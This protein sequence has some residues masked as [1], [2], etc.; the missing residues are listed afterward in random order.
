MN[1]NVLLDTDSYKITHWRQYPP[2]TTRVSSFL[3]SR[4]GVYPSTVFFGLQYILQ[5]HLV[6]PVVTE[7]AIAEA[8]DLCAA[9]FGDPSLFHEAGW[10]HVLEAH[11]GRLPVEIRA[12]PEG[13]EVPVSNVLMTIEN[14]DPRVPWLTNYLESLLLQVWYPC[15][16]ATQ[17]RHM[18][19]TIE[20]YLERTGDPSLASFKLHDFGLRG[21]TSIESSGIGGAAHLVSFQGTDTLPAL[22]L[23]RRHYGAEM[24]GFSIPA[25]EH[26]T[27][28]SWGRDREA[29]AYRNMLESYP[30]GLVAVVSDSYDVFRACAELWGGQLRDAVLARDG[31][32][33][34]R[35][36]SGEPP[37]VVCRV[38]EILG[39]AF[40]TR[41]NDKGYRV[42]DPHV[43]VIQGDGIDH[44]MIVD[45][46]EAM[47]ARG[48]SADN[49][50]FGSGGALLQRVHRDTQ[51][52]AI[53]CSAAE[54]GGE[55]RPVMK[56]PVTDPGKRSK[57]GLL[58]L[59]RDAAGYR[60][61]PRASATHD[62]LEP[63]FRDGA[64]LRTQTFRDIRRRALT[65][66]AT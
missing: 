6:G 10:R 55:W 32:L 65:P 29:D 18:R 41:A 59:E 35:P 48:W 20:S 31:V 13:T 25:A 61:V 36:D 4:G 46:L 37:D 58:A 57:A 22:A 16:V 43:R 33:V 60:T 40:G 49:V 38:L 66:D 64:L 51:R 7:A 15:T 2:G 30:R 24:A 5:R 8:R 23:A 26:S 52:F 56:D 19:R 54:I 27:I 63:V 12:V 50:A 17:S 3:E 9:H 45:I 62:L 1:D 39:E 47:T 11:G 21:S 28:T 42:L 34:V 53:K 14:T 44:A